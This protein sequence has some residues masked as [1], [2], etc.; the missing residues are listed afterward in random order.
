MILK[1]ISTLARYL[2]VI[3][4]IHKRRFKVS[5][6][7]THV[8]CPTLKN[9]RANHN[10]N[11]NCSSQMA[12]SSDNRTLSYIEIKQTT[13]V[14]HTAQQPVKWAMGMITQTLTH[15]WTTHAHVQMWLDNTCGCVC[16]YHTTPPHCTVSYMNIECTTAH[17]TPWMYPNTASIVGVMYPHRNQINWKENVLLAHSTQ[18]STW[19]HPNKPSDIETKY[20]GCIRKSKW[21]QQQQVKTSFPHE[22]TRPKPC[23]LDLKH[24][25]LKVAD[26]SSQHNILTPETS[27]S[28]FRT[29]T[30]S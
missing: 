3:Q 10:I 13:P 8:R 29:T 18:G 28:P 19:P 25:S 4:Q 20:R 27:S 9:W 30:L 26:D 24:A 1:L 7:I 5:Q 14:A 11:F 2:R 17:N 15:D 22:T 21:Q 6:L 12:N 23:N 16:C